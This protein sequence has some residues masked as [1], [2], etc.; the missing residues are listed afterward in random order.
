MLSLYDPD[1]GLNFKLAEEG[2]LKVIAKAKVLEQPD[3]LANDKTHVNG[4]EQLAIACS[5]SS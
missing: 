5:P 2:H 1:R 4:T 3:G